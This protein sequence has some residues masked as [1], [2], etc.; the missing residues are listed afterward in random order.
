MQASKLHGVM[1]LCLFGLGSLANAMEAV[2]RLP[3]PHFTKLIRYAISLLSS[4]Q[5]HTQ[6]HV[7]LFFSL[8]LCFRPVLEVFDDSRG[9]GLYCLLN[10]L[11]AQPG[12]ANTTSSVQQR[13]GQLTHYT[14]LCLRHYLRMH[15]A[16]EFALQGIFKRPR[17][18]SAESQV[19]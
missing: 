11:L 7:V 6:K 2:C 8:A 15:L 12:G 3:A 10:I 17:S 1:V 4:P 9:Q 19:I 5:E 13:R 18:E 16:L 14:C